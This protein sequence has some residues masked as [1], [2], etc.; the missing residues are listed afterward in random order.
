LQGKPEG[1]KPIGKSR[2]R[3]VY[4][5]KMN[6]IDVLCGLVVRVS[7]YR[8]RGPGSILGDISFSEKQ[9]VSKGAHSAS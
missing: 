5:I 8:S 1:K 6:L 3:R 7:D 4:N 2:R 9:W